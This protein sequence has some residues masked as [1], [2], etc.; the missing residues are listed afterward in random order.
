VRRSAPAPYSGRRAL[1]PLP[2]VSAPTAKGP[3]TPGSS[4]RPTDGGP[5]G[6]ATRYP[7][8]PGSATHQAKARI[9]TAGVANQATRAVSVRRFVRATAT[10]MNVR[11]I[12][13]MEISSTTGSMSCFRKLSGHSTSPATYTNAPRI[14]PMGTGGTACSASTTRGRRRRAKTLRSTLHTRT[15]RPSPAD[16][17]AKPRKPM[18]R[19]TKIRGTPKSKSRANRA[20]T[21]VAPT[22]RPLPKACRAT[23]AVRG[24]ASVRRTVP[25]KLGGTATMLWTGMV[26]CPLHRCVAAAA[27]RIC[28]RVA[29]QGLAPLPTRPG[30]ATPGDRRSRHGDPPT[31]LTPASLTGVP[32]R[33]A[34]PRRGAG[35]QGLGRRVPRE[36]HH[37]RFYPRPPLAGDGTVPGTGRVGPRA[38]RARP[39]AVRAMR[40]RPRAG[41]HPYMDSPCRSTIG[42]VPSKSTSTS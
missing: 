25:T 2:Y 20:E 4:T 18:S 14:R 24:V 33:T 30:G 10:A 23:T 11:P 1:V 32:G 5:T 42:P 8:K 17:K 3:R 9:A 19:T 41:S 31:M 22:S 29:D 6:P 38:P 26:G 16:T 37:G 36:L 13:T 21:A 12:S 15:T 27:G 40:S 28:A 7:S 34:P 39:R 35:K